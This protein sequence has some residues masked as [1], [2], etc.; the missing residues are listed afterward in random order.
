MIV[1][2]LAAL[3]F[4]AANVSANVH[5]VEGTDTA[6]ASGVGLD[7]YLPADPRGAVPAVLFVH[8][9]GWRSGDKHGWARRSRDF[10]ERTGW[11]AFAVNYD[12]DAAEPW[13]TQPANVRDAIA[14][15]RANAARLGVDPARIGLV[16]SSAGGHLVML[17]GTTGAGVSAV[18]SWSGITDLPRLAASPR[19][20]QLVKDLAVRYDGGTLDEQPSRWI[21]SSPV[22]HVDPTD[23]PMLL[24]GSVDETVVPIDQLVTM[25]NRLHANGVEVVT[26][27]LPGTRHA[28]NFGDDVWDQ[29]VQ[30]LVDHV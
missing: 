30:F 26:T 23:P 22:A 18:V 25:Q 28:S 24:V 7:S 16:G 15:V 13:V 20:D 21:Q 2:V 14:W 19:G 5:V 29:T 9:G 8:G 17:V 12:L 10:V 27:V 11:A 3:V 6:Y 4:G 1:G